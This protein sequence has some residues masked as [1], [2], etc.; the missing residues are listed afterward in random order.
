MGI[1]LHQNKK[2]KSYV[3]AWSAGV[4]M[5]LK[6]DLMCDRYVSWVGKKSFEAKTLLSAGFQFIEKNE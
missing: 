3:F 6:N 4:T 1:A 5:R 2:S